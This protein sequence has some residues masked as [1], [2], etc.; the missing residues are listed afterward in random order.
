MGRCAATD[1]ML[2][3]V[4]R[5]WR[6]I[7]GSTARQHVITARRFTARIASQSAGLVPTT[8][9]KDAAPAA[10]NLRAVMVCCR[11]VL[12]I[13]VRQRR[14]TI[15]NVASIAAQRP[16]PGAAVYTATKAG[17]IG[18]SRVLAEELRAE[19]VRVGVLVPG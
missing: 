8:G 17:V 19:G 1:A 11:A 2:T 15:I 6:I 18:F 5:C 16:I 4:P 7:A 9:P 12:P 14:G 13:M 3:I 10:V